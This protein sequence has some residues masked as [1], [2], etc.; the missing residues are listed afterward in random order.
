MLHVELCWLLHAVA[1]L[2]VRSYD[3]VENLESI[4]VHVPIFVKD[5]PHGTAGM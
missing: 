3:S 1:Q 4:V 5:I 2:S